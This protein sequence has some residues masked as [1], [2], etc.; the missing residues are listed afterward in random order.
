MSVPRGFR[1]TRR[2]WLPLTALF[3]GLFVHFVLYGWLVSGFVGGLGLL[4]VFAAKLGHVPFD[5]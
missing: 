4:W 3:A 2:W 1:F 5:D